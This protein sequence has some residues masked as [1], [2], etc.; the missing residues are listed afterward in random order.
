MPDHQ[1]EEE[2]KGQ[3][4]SRMSGVGPQAARPKEYRETDAVK[5]KTAKRAEM[6]VGWGR[7]RWVGGIEVLFGHKC[8]WVAKHPN[9]DHVILEAL[10]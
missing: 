6:G 4:R 5:C 8:S 9:F 2:N 7:D 10:Q 3:W 1:Q